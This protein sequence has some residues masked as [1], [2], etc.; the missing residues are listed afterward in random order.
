MIRP[1]LRDKLGTAQRATTPVGNRKESPLQRERVVLA[2]G[3]VQSRHSR[4][5]NDGKKTLCLR[6]SRVLY[7]LAEVP[8]NPATLPFSRTFVAEAGAAMWSRY[9]H[10]ILR[11]FRLVVNPLVAYCIQ[12]RN[13]RYLAEIGTRSLTRTG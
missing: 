1:Q 3:T 4:D 12:T 6:F 7:T 11:N 9:A 13:L 8:S 2:G 5:Q 10:S